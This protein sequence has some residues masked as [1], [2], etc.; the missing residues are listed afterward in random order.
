[1]Y[2][3]LSDMLDNTAQEQRSESNTTVELILIIELVMGRIEWESLGKEM[4]LLVMRDVL[5]LCSWETIINSILNKKY[6]YIK[7]FKRRVIR[8]MCWY[9]LLKILLVAAWESVTEAKTLG[10]QRL[11]IL[12]HYDNQRDFRDA[13]WAGCIWWH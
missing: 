9:L 4:D 11:E 7:I 13:M 6:T 3:G 12:N 1:M 5:E 2:N 10:D 8:S